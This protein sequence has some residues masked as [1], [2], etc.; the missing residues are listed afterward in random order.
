MIDLVKKNAPCVA[1][2]RQAT[3]QTDDQHKLV[4]RYK[5]IAA[6][7]CDPPLGYDKPDQWHGYIPPA[8]DPEGVDGVTPL[9]TSPQRV[10]LMALL[11]EAAVRADAEMGRAA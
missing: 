8:Y 5:D 6:K 4:M 11:E 3:K 9:N 2:A 1:A 7:L 10:A